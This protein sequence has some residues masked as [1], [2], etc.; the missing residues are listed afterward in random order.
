MRTQ[1]AEGFSGTRTAPT[2]SAYTSAARSD[3]TY[4]PKRCISAQY[5]RINALSRAC[6]QRALN[7]GL[8]RWR[9]QIARALSTRTVRSGRAT[10]DT[11]PR[12]ETRFRTIIPGFGS[13]IARTP[14]AISKAVCSA[15]AALRRP[16]VHARRTARAAIDRDA[17]SE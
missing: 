9:A 3:A 8:S 7:S 10:Y 2:V 17:L 14:L 1:S 16:R 4:P 6:G 13:L 12:D 11:L 5:A 15:R